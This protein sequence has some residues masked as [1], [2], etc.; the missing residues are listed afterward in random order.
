MGYGFGV[1]RERVYGGERVRFGDEKLDGGC[2]FLDAV[3]FLIHSLTTWNSRRYTQTEG[4]PGR[5][6]KRTDRC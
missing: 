1:R 5:G 3:L 6:F 4:I 2:V